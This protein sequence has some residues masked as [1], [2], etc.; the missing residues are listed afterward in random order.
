[1]EKT[2]QTLNVEACSIIEQ[3]GGSAELARKL[4]FSGVNGTVRVNNWK[5]RGIPWEMKAKHPSIFNLQK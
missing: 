5:Y 4:N 3:H 2:E 1:M